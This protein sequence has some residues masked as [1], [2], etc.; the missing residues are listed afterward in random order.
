[1]STV[2][3]LTFSGKAVSD[4]FRYRARGLH[5]PSAAALACGSASQVGGW[6]AAASYFSVSN[7][8]KAPP[9][10]TWGKWRA[11]PVV[12]CQVDPVIGLFKQWSSTVAKDGPL[13]RT[14]L[15][16]QV[17]GPSLLTCPAWVWRV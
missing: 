9:C 1:M 16:C 8:E 12:V 14:G 11:R 2:Q 17:D 4:E 15:A 5:P 6:G 3:G 10:L 7:L 13:Q